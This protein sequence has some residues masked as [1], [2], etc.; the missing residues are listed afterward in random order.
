MK[1]TEIQAAFTKYYM[2]RA[3]TEFAEDLD[4]IRGADDFKD[5]ALPLLINAL[6]QGTSTFSIEEQRRI[7]TAG[8]QK[9]GKEAGD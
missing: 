1:D 4:K 5:D 8:M 2:Q 6:Q 7:V 3:T 9:E